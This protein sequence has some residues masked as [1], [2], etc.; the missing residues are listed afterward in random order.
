MSSARQAADMYNHDYI[1]PEHILIGIL[2][3]GSAESVAM[4]EKLS[5]K[6]AKLLSSVESKMVVVGGKAASTQL[7]FTGPAKKVLEHSIH[8]AILLEHNYVGIEH[9]LLGLLRVENTL[10]AEAFKSSNISYEDIREKIKAFVGRDSAG[11]FTTPSTAS[12]YN[13]SATLETLLAGRSLTSQAATE[14]MQAIVAGH[15]GAASIAALAVALRAKGETIEELAAFARVMRESSVR[16]E[17][18]EDTIDTCGTGGDG[19]GTFNISTAAALIAAGMGIPI[20][21]HGARSASSLTGSA[22]VL[23]ALGV[24]IDANAECVARCIKRAGIGFMFAPSHHPGLKHV[25]PVR[26]E[27]GIKTFFNLTGP[28]SNPAN[29]GRQVI[30]VYDPSLCEKFAQVL[31]ML[32]SRSAMIVC[33]TGPGGKGHLDEVS[34]FGPTA[35]ARL[36]EGRIELTR[37]EATTLGIPLAEPGALSAA[38]ATESAATIRSI[39]DGQKGVPRDIAALNAAAAAIVAGQAIEWGEAFGLAQK[40]IDSGAAKRALEKLVEEAKG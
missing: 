20:A 10:A 28:L 15:V 27:L 16:V 36:S 1:G 24:N 2:N 7:P 26:R 38:N 34:T 6:S 23:K 9:L 35:I 37:F 13:I 33:G 8:E 4:L 17:A 14:L 18:P 22:D 40:S 25:A 21:K 5:I 11:K 12:L 30:G 3:E 39:L 29:T 32:G 31:H 19:S